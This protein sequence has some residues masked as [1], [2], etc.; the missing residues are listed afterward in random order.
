MKRLDDKLVSI[1]ISAIFD[2]FVD[3]VLECWSIGQSFNRIH[4]S[5]ITPKTPILS[6]FLGMKKNSI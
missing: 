5:A 3:G 2:I 1:E 6:I 4:R